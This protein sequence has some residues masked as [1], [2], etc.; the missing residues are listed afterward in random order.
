M[1]SALPP[2]AY[3]TLSDLEGSSSRV[4]SFCLSYCSWGS[5]GKSSGVAYHSLLQWNTF[6][7]NSSL[8]PVRLGCPCTAWLVGPLSYASPFAMTRLWSM[9]GSLCLV[10]QSCL[11]LCDPLDCSLP[12]SSS[13]AFSRQEYWSGLP[14]PSP[15]IFPNEGSNPGLPHWRQTL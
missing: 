3:W 14:F 10:A 12:G 9:K 11:T 4:I 1:P 15:G 6:C 8:W 13:M 7:Q 2:L 5:Q